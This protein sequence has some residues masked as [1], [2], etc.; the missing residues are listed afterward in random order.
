MGSTTTDRLWLALADKELKPGVTSNEYPCPKCGR[1][2]SFSVTKQRNG[3]ILYFCHRANCPCRGV[4]GGHLGPSPNPKSFVPR[5]YLGG[6][7]NLDVSEQTY[8]VGLYNLS[9]EAI[10]RAM[11]RYGVEDDRLVMPVLS[12]F[13]GHRGYI[14]KRIGPGLGPKTDT[15]RE[16]EGVFIGWNRSECKELA[17]TAVIVEDCISALRASEVVDAVAIL[18]T[19]LN[20]EMVEEITQH[21]RRQVICLDRDSKK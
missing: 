20:A 21:T 3:I 13:R 5:P 11:W 17:G 2:K 6:L 8:L 14:A 18:G 4:Y 10:A 9:Q 15:Y 1:S 19:H 7:R 16:E 12:P